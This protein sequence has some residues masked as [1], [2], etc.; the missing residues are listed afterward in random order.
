MVLRRTP[1]LTAALAALLG[2]VAHAHSGEVTWQQSLGDLAVFTTAL[3]ILLGLGWQGLAPLWR[4]EGLGRGSR[5]VLAGLTVGLLVAL[6]A[7]VGVGT[8]GRVISP[9]PPPP[10]SF[11][12][13]SERGG[14]VART[15]S[16]F[17]ELSRR[18]DEFRL[19]LS[20]ELRRPIGPEHFSGTLAAGGAS[21]ALEARAGYRSARLAVRGPA[22]VEV[23]LAVPGDRMRL[24][25]K[26][27]EAGRLAPG[28]P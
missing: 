21:A 11:S 17:V 7:A 18:G 27:D 20:D 6:L 19:W 26:I 14:A 12:S 3:G 16:Y 5:W 2:G 23:D 15:G 24:V 25:W 4:G 22:S 8:V 9:P 13:R 28:E 1:G 10:E